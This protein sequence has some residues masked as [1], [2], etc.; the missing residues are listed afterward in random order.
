[1]ESVFTIGDTYTKKDIYGILGVPLNAQ[2]EHGIL[3]TEN[4]KTKY[5][6]L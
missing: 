3:D 2:K 1:M 4:I 6:Y 5:L